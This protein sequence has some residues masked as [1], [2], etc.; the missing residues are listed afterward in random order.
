MVHNLQFLFV[1]NNTQ[2]M[3]YTKDLALNQY[4]L[5]LLIL[6]MKTVDVDFEISYSF[7]ILSLKLIK[8]ITIIILRTY[9]LV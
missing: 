3:K 7:K 8:A 5:T 9:Q 6:S 2:K 1:Q 4:N